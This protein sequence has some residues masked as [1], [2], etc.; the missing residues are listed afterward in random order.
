[1]LMLVLVPMLVPLDLL[2]TPKPALPVGYWM[3]IHP[4]ASLCR[5]SRY[6]MLRFRALGS[7]EVLRV[8][9]VQEPHR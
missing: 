2:G 1:M 3:P 5:I 9:A 4:A 6:A 7:C 8:F